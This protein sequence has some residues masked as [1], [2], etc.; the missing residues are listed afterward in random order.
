MSAALTNLEMQE[1]EKYAEQKEQ[2]GILHREKYLPLKEYSASLSSQI[3]QARP[4]ESAHAIT[5]SVQWSH[6]QL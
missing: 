4:T 6:A 2:F 5:R 3:L 1:K